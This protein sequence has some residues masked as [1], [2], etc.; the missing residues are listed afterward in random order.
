MRVGRDWWGRQ[1]CLEPESWKGRAD[2]AVIGW[3]RGRISGLVS[4]LGAGGG[5]CETAKWTT[6]PAGH[7]IEA[8]GLQIPVGDQLDNLGLLLW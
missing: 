5:R 8:T 3:L 7:A 4:S 6:Q 2:G 1:C